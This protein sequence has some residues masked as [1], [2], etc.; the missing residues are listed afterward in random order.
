MLCS[1]FLL[2]ACRGD[3][4]TWRSPNEKKTTQRLDPSPTSQQRP[5]LETELAL[6]SSLFNFYQ[7]GKLPYPIGASLMNP[8]TPKTKVL[9]PCPFASMG[10]LDLFEKWCMYTQGI[11]LFHWQNDS[12]CTPL[13]DNPLNTNNKDSLHIGLSMHPSQ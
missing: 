9:E 5:A 2:H 4:A 8:L 7:L 11:A 10:Y 3:V 1:Q 6:Y 12:G 13:L